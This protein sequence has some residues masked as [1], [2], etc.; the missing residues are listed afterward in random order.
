MNSNPY[1]LENKDLF[2]NR[3]ELLELIKVFRYEVQQAQRPA[4]EWII[5]DSDLQKLLKVSKR[6]TAN[7]RAHG[8]ITY[9]HLG[10]KVVYLYSDVL[11]AIN[12]NKI[13]AIQEQLRIKLSH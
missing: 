7:Y 12:R 9:S 4:S 6:T 11:D 8:L 10:G 1:V 2:R 5:D 13:P 3:P